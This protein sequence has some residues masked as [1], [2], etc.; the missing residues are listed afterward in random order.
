[1]RTTR[2]SPL[3]GA[4]RLANCLP[5]PLRSALSRREDEDS[6]LRHAWHA[7]VAEPL[8]SHVHPVRYAAGLLFVHV[9]TPAWASRLRHEK[10]G[11]LDLLRKSPPFRDIADIR[12]RV[13]PV[14]PATARA[15]GPVRPSRLSGKAAKVVAQTAANIAHPELRAA[16]E[17][18]ARR[19]G[20][21]RERRST[22][23]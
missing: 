14:D 10:P 20:D 15:P 17:R 2:T 8:A 22:R 4:K 3:S 11:I 6:R 18:L 12:F 5:E 19:A 13:I 9:N 7:T 1:M 23:P 16:L 21:P